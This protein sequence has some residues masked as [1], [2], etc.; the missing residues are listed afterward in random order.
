MQSKYK[1]ENFKFPD[2][3]VYTSVQTGKGNIVAPHF[4]NAA[5]LNLILSG[6]GVFYINTEALHCHESD[7]VFIPPGC[8]H[9]FFS[10]NENTK[11]KGI[12]FELSAIDFKSNEDPVSAYLSKETV[13][14]YTVSRNKSVLCEYIRDFSL[15]DQDG[16]VNKLNVLSKIYK[17]CSALI[18]NYNA[19]TTESDNNRIKPVIDYVSENF[20]HQIYISTLSSLIN[21]S[22][23][24]L[25]RLF[26]TATNKSPIEYITDLRIEEALR[27][28]VKD[29]AS[30]T[31]I[32]EDVGFSNVNYMIK[33]FKRKL[34]T[35]PNKYRKGK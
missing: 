25:I 27:L 20:R 31:Q 4:H 24:H 9:T 35:T 33:I 3:P 7:I 2:F 19:K 34:N 22:D 30:I 17:I 11:I 28:L 10:N 21:V 1:F 15:N 14:E 13:K 5:E 18:E 32:A 23:S 16:I 26:K 8:V 12:T 29:D 6:E